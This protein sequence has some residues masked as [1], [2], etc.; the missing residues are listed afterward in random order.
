MGCHGVN[1]CLM[2]TA[3][4][5]CCESLAHSQSSRALGLRFLKAKCNAL[6]IVCFGLV[7]TTV[8]AAQSNDPAGSP[9]SGGPGVAID[10]FEFSYGLAHPSLPALEQLKGLTVK[11]TR[12]GNVFRAPAAK[13]AENLTLSG[14]P[15]GSRF[16]GDA[17]RGIAQDV[18][19]WYNA[20][21]LYGVWVAYSDLEPS[22]SG[23]VDNR[24]ADDRVAH[25]VI[26]ASQ[27]SEVRT[28]ARGKRIKP[29]LS[30]NNPKH[31]RII[32]NSPLHAGAKPGQ[33][34]SLFRQDVLDSYLHG[35]S[36][37]P[38]RRVEASIASA[39][40]PGKVV[41]DF[42][43]NESKAWLLFSQVNNYGTDA[44]GVIRA[45]LG[46][47][48]NQLTNHDDILNVDV[49]S[50]PN[51]KTYGSFLSYRIP[52]WRP[53]KLLFRIYGSYGDFLASGDTS[54]ADL[55]YAGKNWLGGFELTN[56]LTLWHDW[57]LQSAL[58]A[59]FNHYGIQSLINKTPFVTGASNFLVPFLGTTLSRDYA[60]GSVSGAVRFDHTVG[61]FANADQTTGYP[62]LGRASADPDW[63]S[64][65]WD[66]SG[67]VYLDQL[68]DRSGKAQNL[69]HEFS[70]RLK[71]R[72]LLR[73]KRM[74]PQE[75]EPL[76]GAL[77]VR[78]YAESILS[79]D[80]F[81]AATFE[82]AYHIPRGLK[83][84]EPGT[85]FRR[86]FKWHPVQ[87]GQNPDWDL[88]PR[89][90][91][92]YAYRAVTPPPAGTAG[93]TTGPAPL[94]DRN[95]SMAGV[96]VGVSLVVKQNFSLRCDFGMSLIELKDP[97]LE[98]KKQIVSPKGNKHVYLV[99]SFSW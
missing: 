90:F 37:H 53:A 70:A 40:E 71:G 1:P 33:P 18:V 8:I 36:L 7:F 26:W 83:P 66:L 55:R 68:F 58:G 60:W 89:A 91:F 73:G 94:N 22:V 62:A 17:L 20:R 95:V 29:Q 15:E 84:A 24:P 92:D 79:A 75:Q 11:S 19:R 56:Q 45:R 6:L 81:V 77:T 85:L 41:L 86:P 87:A 97:S 59:N 32:L 4:I 12:E 10:H 23:L 49:I 13:G 98:D 31:R 28:L 74:I 52:V 69:V 43:V 76:G 65:R 54:L 16:D 2:R 80:E 99:S 61:R 9:A 39:G 93:Q 64:L 67:T 5:Y 48:D 51:F 96:G 3:P 72:K 34:G 14:I 57:R 38:G 25:L 42:L 21:G 82:Y 50:T 88:A 47:Q 44:T 78:G 46:F 30:I 27:I 35:L 63:T